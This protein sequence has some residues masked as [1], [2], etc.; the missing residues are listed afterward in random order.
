MTAM[1][2]SRLQCTFQAEPDT[3]H[4]LQLLCHKLKKLPQ[5]HKAFGNKLLQLLQGCL[6]LLRL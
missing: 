5:L 1:G 6:Q 2:S 4:L 3:K